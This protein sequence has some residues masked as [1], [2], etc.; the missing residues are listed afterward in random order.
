MSVLQPFLN[1]GLTR[2]IFN[3]SGKTANLIV[4]FTSLTRVGK[5][6][7]Q[8]SLMARELIISN[9]VAFFTSDLLII[10]KTSLNSNYL[11]CRVSLK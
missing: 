3:L 10:D 4:K 2:A 5:S 1:S 8:F 9:P 6:M 7:A 11:F